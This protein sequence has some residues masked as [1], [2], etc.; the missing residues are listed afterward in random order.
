MQEKEYPFLDY[1]VSKKFDEL[2]ELKLIE[3]LEMKWPDE[4]GNTND[5]NYCKYHRLLGYPLESVSSSM[6]KSCNWLGKE[7]IILDDEKVNSN[8]ISI[9]FGSLDPI[10]IYTPKKENPL[11]P[12]KIQI[13]RDNN[14]V[15]ILVTRRICEKTS[16]QKNHLRNRPEEEW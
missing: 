10:Q 2:V 15:W 12:N 5:P 3:L 14:E 6:T 13:N 1:D 16:S 9:T 7:K 8:Q 11:E 4:A